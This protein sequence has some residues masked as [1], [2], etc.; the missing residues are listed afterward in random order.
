VGVA[1]HK[2]LVLRRHVPEMHAV[3]ALHAQPRLERVGRVVQSVLACRG[4]KG[5]RKGRKTE[6][7]MAV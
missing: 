1:V 2:E 3:R 4:K 5:R 7:G 6:E